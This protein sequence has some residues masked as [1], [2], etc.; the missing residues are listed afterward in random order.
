[1]SEKSIT[2][3]QLVTENQE[4]IKE[5]QRLKSQQFVE[6]QY[7]NFLQDFQGIAYR[8]DKRWKPLFFH[9]AVEHLTGYTE[10]EL[11]NLQPDWYEIVS[12]EDLPDLKK[13]YPDKEFR[14]T[15]FKAQREYRIVSR[16]GEIRW[17]N[18]SIQ[19][20]TDESGELIYIQGAIFDITH[21]KQAEER[22]RKSEAKY[23]ELAGQ[24]AETNNLKELLLDVITHDL[25]NAAGNIYG[26]AN[27]IKEQNPGIEFLNHIETSSLAL[28]NVIDNASTLAK[29]SA[30]EKI[31][32]S[33]LNLT[34]I[35]RDSLIEFG[36]L[37]GK[38]LVEIRQHLR[39][40]LMVNAN[41]IISE[42]FKNYISNAI[43]YGS[44][45]KLIIIEALRDGL[46]VRVMVRDF[47]NTIPEADRQIIFERKVTLD[48]NQRH[49]GGLGLAIVKKI[50]EVH[51]AEAWVEPNNPTGNVF[52]LQIKSA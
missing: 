7:R 16:S 41:P 42:V 48:K 38:G 21:G 36:P 5:L 33:A 34:D 20:I 17:V 3:E 43:K 18:D 49:T 50:A 37:N 27:L 30:G 6:N 29:I 52:C 4:L 26:F 12:P 51:G 24:L 19:S 40:G 25:R 2:K 45:G 14:K 32:L 13:K 46:Y 10:T 15:G 1:M 11:L 22:M 8:L 9:G 23:R 39:E 31:N 44:A 35:I 47:G 28:I